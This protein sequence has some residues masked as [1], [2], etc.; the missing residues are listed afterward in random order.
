MYYDSSNKHV[1]LASGHSGVL[2]EYDEYG[3]NV[4]TITLDQN[5]NPFMNPSGY[6]TIKR[7]FYLNNEE[8]AKFYYD[9]DGNPTATT[10]GN[11][12]MYCSGEKN[13]LLDQN[14]KEVFNIQRFLTN[15]EMIVV[16]IVIVV[17]C[18]TLL[19]PK[20]YIRILLG[21]SILS[22][23]YL[24][25][26]NRAQSNLE[27]KFELFWSYKQF[28]TDKTLQKEILLNILLFLPL[29]YLLSFITKNKRYVLLAILFS[30]CIEIVQLVFGLGVFEYDDMISN[31]IGSVL[32]YA[33]GY[34]ITKILN[35]R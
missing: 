10:K 7:T 34:F 19:V 33:I 23:L 29:G 32:G 13:I 27:P 15:N 8:K 24:T 3:R 35:E 25:L 4:K 11:Y 28:F 14:N 30:V 2:K 16:L 6:S 20:K 17:I 21:M 18:I 22:I 9:I 31:G 26:F 5:G 1:L 12:G